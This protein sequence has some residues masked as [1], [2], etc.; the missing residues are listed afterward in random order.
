MGCFG[1]GS[2]GQA[3]L[4]AEQADF[5]KQLSQET[6]AMYGNFQELAKGISAA[7]QPILDKGI[8]QLGF[9]P[10]EK[11]T[12]DT[13]ATEHV[14]RNFQKAKVAASN[15]IAG[16]GGGDA[17][18]PSGAKDQINA[19]LES[20]AAGESSDLENKIQTEDYQVGRQNYL[21]ASGALSGVMG[22]ENP[23]AMANATTNAGSAAER[24]F[25]D[26]SA[27]D[28]AWMSPVLGAIGGI[29]GGALGNPNVK[30]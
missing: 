6:T 1:G 29:A 10:G 16:S 23:A 14:A 18:N 25:Q 2:S 21:D 27:E 4:S 17:T 26:I 28:S 19:Q 13:A 9:D 30:F 15:A 11:A 8:N 3:A 12:L 22:M 7:W 20:S 5:F 24:T